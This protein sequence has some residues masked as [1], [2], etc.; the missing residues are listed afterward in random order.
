MNKHIVNAM[1]FIDIPQE[2]ISKSSN[3]RII[4]KNIISVENHLGISI[5]TETMTVI[6]LYHNIL[7]ICGDNLVIDEINK[8]III[9]KGCIA[10]IKFENME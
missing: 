7:I 10:S 1:E 4:E 5:Y 9:L 8:E 3:I 2:I 6:K